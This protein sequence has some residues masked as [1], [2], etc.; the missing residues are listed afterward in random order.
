MGGRR[1]IG[2]TIQ[3][4]KFGRRIKHGWPRARRNFMA[5]VSPISCG[6]QL[7]R[8]S[9]RKGPPWMFS[10]ARGFESMATK[11]PKAPRGW[12]LFDGSCG[13]CSWWISYWAGLLK[14]RGFD[15]APLQADWVQ[16]R[17]RFT[18]EEVLKD[19]R[20]LFQD[21]ALISGA[22]A[23]LFIFGEIPW[24]RPLGWFFGLPGPRQIF[25][26][27]YRLFNRNRFWVSKACRL[28]PMI[29]SDSKRI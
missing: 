5:L 8:H 6:G 27:V 11:V 14:K 2:W 19:I 4:G 3:L 25:G 26:A 15:T 24:T 10:P 21:N 1:N 7:I 9:W 28:K 23:Y 18:S 12:I 17:A 29:S 13:F 20:I 16:A 22:D